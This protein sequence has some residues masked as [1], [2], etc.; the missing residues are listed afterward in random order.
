[1][2]QLGSAS[3][4]SVI[5]AD[6]LVHINIFAKYY[7]DNV[8]NEDCWWWR[9]NDGYYHALTHRMTPA[10]REGVESGGHAFAASLDDC[11]LHFDILS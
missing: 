6:T 9:S 2:M 7:A 5:C 3:I 10:D 11:A 1:M 8:T 4:M